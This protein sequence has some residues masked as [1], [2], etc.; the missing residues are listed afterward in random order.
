MTYQLVLLG[1]NYAAIQRNSQGEIIALVP[2]MSKQMEVALSDEYGDIM[3]QYTDGANVKVFSQKS[4]WQ[5][6]LFGN[7]IIGLSPLEYARNSLGIGL[8]AERAVAKVYS[9]GGKPSGVLMIDAFLTPDQRETVRRNFAGVTEGD[10]NRMFVLEKGT[11]FQQVSLSPQD[12]ELLASRRFQIEDIARFFGVPSVLINDNSQT[13]VW[14]TGI[15]QIVQGFYKL[16]LRPYIERYEAGMKRAL[17][18]PEERRIYEFEFDLSQLLRPDLAERVTAGKTAVQGGLITPNEWRRE[19][20]MEPK[21]GGD[22]LL[23]QQQ[24]I[25]LPM[26]GEVNRG[27]G[28]NGTAT[29]QSNA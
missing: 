4:V 17:L 11:K 29:D 6:K 1:N 16:G 25:A 7:G 12:I 3:Y 24:M 22:D 20:G 9:N 18:T 26:L 27:G 2:L 10:D 28:N 5:N 13:T 21:K 19:E 23:V 14:G 15:Q 8:A